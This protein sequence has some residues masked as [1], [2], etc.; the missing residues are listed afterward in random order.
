M[1]TLE[2][3]LKRED[4]RFHVDAWGIRH[5]SS[6]SDYKAT[7]GLFPDNRVALSRLKEG[8][9]PEGAVYGVTKDGDFVVPK[10]L[11][12][13]VRHRCNLGQDTVTPAFI[14]GV[15]Q[16]LA[17]KQRQQNLEHNH[18]DDMERG[19]RRKRTRNLRGP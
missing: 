13:E 14:M 8:E 7:Q 17:E 9:L 1:P 6:P 10:D 4:I 2:R 11:Q 15:A 16:E 3:V 19:L 12:K 18:D 5:Y